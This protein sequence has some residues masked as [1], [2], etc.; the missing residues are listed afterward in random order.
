M[1]V[2]GA[3]SPGGVVSATMTNT[4]TGPG[5]QHGPRDQG[6]PPLVTAMLEWKP[7]TQE[8]DGAGVTNNGGPQGGLGQHM[9]SALGSGFDSLTSGLTHTSNG[10]DNGVPS[11]MGMPMHNG[12]GGSYLG[13]MVEVGKKSVLDV[14]TMQQRSMADV[15]G[16]FVCGCFSAWPTYYMHMH[17]NEHHPH[18]HPNQPPV[19]IPPTPPP[20]DL[21]MPPGSIHSNSQ[22]QL[23]QVLHDLGIQLSPTPP[24]TSQEA[25]RAVQQLLLADAAP[26]GSTTAAPTTPGG[27]YAPIMDA[28]S[29][30]SGSQQGRQPV[31]ASPFAHLQLPD[32]MQGG[33]GASA[34][35]GPGSDCPPLDLDQY[36]SGVVGLDGM[37]L[38]QLGGMRS[39]L[40]G[41]G[42]VELSSLHAGSG[43]LAPMLRV[44]QQQSGMVLMVVRG[45]L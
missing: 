8:T 24:P 34:H 15:L 38:S 16:M 45:R 32:S 17:R 19:Y 9:E 41:S 3:A 10:M 33:G 40:G 26:V 18:Q 31:P 4:M 43:A 25:I 20:T 23:S 14:L 30:A 6:G 2:G 5:D 29:L 13:D 36:G 21:P 1:D 12:G 11:S 7:F 27:G 39:S 37:L 22:S 28:S 44:L 42:A 35:G